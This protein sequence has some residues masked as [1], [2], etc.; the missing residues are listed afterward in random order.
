MLVIEA[1][2]EHHTKLVESAPPWPHISNRYTILCN[3]LRYTSY[4]TLL[5]GAIQHVECFICWP[6]T[7]HGTNMTRWTYLWVEHL[8]ASSTA[9]GQE[10]NFRK[11]NTPYDYNSIVHYGR[12]VSQRRPTDFTWNSPS[13]LRRGSSA[14]CSVSALRGLWKDWRQ[15][16]IMLMSSIMCLGCTDTT[17]NSRLILKWACNCLW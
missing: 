16:E 4:S 2:S 8:N 6:L 11:I 10:H 14:W 13:N 15:Y 12:S 1:T 17:A 7:L 5:M 3:Y 9:A